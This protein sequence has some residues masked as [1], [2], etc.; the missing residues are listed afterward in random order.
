MDQQELDSIYI[1]LKEIEAILYL[2]SN[3]NNDA[4]IGEY[5]PIIACHYQDILQKVIKKI[6]KYL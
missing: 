2:F 6:E 4:L 1:E 3:I 5:I